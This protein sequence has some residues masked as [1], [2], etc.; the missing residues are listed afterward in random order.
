[1]ICFRFSSGSSGKI[2]TGSPDLLDDPTLL[3][4]IVDDVLTA[5][6]PIL[7]E[8]SEKLPLRRF[9]ET[10]SPT[11]AT[12]QQTNINTQFNYYAWFSFYN[13]LLLSQS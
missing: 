2:E 5:T 8:S 11:P 4:E 1:M 9:A 3:E 10:L 6:G 12:C 13:S 7:E